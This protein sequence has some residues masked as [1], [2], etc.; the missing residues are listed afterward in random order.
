MAELFATTMIS[1]ERVKDFNQRFTTILNKF[2][3][4]DKPTQELLIEV[5]ANDLPTS[6]S[7]F[8]KRPAKLTLV[9]N[10]E[11]DKMIEF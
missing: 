4:E 7:M 6:I 8:V 9:E 2:Q 10:F 5:Y 3:P 11:E 1:K